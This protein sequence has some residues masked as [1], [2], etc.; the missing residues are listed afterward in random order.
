MLRL[1]PDT[2]NIG[3]FPGYCWLQHR[4]LSAP[5]LCPSSPKSGAANLLQTFSSMLANPALRLRQGDTL[6]ITTS[7]DIAALCSMPWQAN[8]HTFDELEMYASM[9]FEKNHKTVD[10]AWVVHSAFRHFGST[11]MAYALPRTW[12][13]QL[14]EQAAQRG[15]RLQTVM[16]IT[17]RAY[18]NPPRPLRQGQS[19]VLLHESTRLSALVYHHGGM[20]AYDVEP[21]IGS[22]TASAR[23]LLRRLNGTHEKI[24]QINLWTQDQAGTEILSETIL[25]E[26][27]EAQM[28]I[29]ATAHWK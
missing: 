19:L 15:L 2:V 3:L 9:C 6:A 17:A 11:G 13:A 10:A 28:A 27:P 7:D 1:W 12:L 25:A 14:A 22:A 24:R 18:F 5:A 21:I 26:L 29:L 20:L 23:R 16:P 8:L 4:S